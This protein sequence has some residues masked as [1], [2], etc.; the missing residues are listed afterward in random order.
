MPF[1]RRPRVTLRKDMGRHHTQLEGTG[2]VAPWIRILVRNA[3]GRRAAHGTRVLVESYREAGG[4][5][6]VTLGSPELGWPSTS[7]SPGGGPVVFSGG[8]RP[9][10]FGALCTARRDD[11]GLLVGWGQPDPSDTK[12]PKGTKWDLRLPLAMHGYEPPLFVANHRAPRHTYDAS[13]RSSRHERRTVLVDWDDCEN[14]PLPPVSCPDCLAGL[15]RHG[16]VGLAWPRCRPRGRAGTG[17]ASSSP[18]RGRTARG[19]PS[20]GEWVVRT[21]GYT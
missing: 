7:L 9:L 19:E 21:G 10:D 2:S 3:R 6:I 12:P 13:T 20:P 5:E 4:A 18:F 8:D 14:A 15:D 1:A 17:R 11:D 16:V